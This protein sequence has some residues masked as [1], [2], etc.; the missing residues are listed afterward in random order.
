MNAIRLKKITTLFV[1]VLAGASLLHSASAVAADTRRETRAVSGPITSVRLIGPIDMAISQGETHGVI[2]EGEAQDLAHITIEISGGEMSVRYEQEKSAW[3]NFSS[4]HSLRAIVA[5]PDIRKVAVVGSG[6]V[7]MSAFNLN[8]GKLEIEVNGSGD[9]KLAN[10]KAKAL[11]VR[12]RGSGDVTAI[13][14]VS[15]QEIAITGSGDYSG[16]ELQ[17]QTSAVSV[18]GSGDAKVWA[19][20]TLAVS[21]AGSGDVAYRG[22]P[23][24]QQSIAGSGE[25][26]QIR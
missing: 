21:I 13:G 25:V 16:T 10:L 22:Q 6:D 20:D 8:D 12:I 4:H 2:V 18:K 15:A 5:M 17:T 26:H 7:A 11:A 14:Q 24:L 9:V 23:K 3:V 19:T 1:V